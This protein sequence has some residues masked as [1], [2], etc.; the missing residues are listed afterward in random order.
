MTKSLLEQSILELEQK[1]LLQRITQEVDPYLEMADLHLESVEK[2]GPAL[3]FEKVKGS[4]FRAV[5]NLF[6]TEERAHFLLRKSFHTV[7]K[8]FQLKA[9]PAAM[10]R[11]E[12]F[13][14]LKPLWHARTMLPKKV[15][16]GEVQYQEIQISDLPQVQSWPMDGGAFL[17]L[18]QV[19]SLHPSSSSIQRSNLGMYRIQ[20]SGNCYTPDEEIGLHYQI[21]RTIGVHHTE[22]VKQGR[23]LKVSIFLGG[24]PAHTLA[25]V[26]PAPEN[27]SELTLA[28]ALAG[29]RFRYVEEDGF[30]LSADADFC[31]TGEIIPDKLLPE[32]PFGDHLGYYSLQHDFPV[33]KVHKVYARKD[34]IF[35][36]TVVGRPPQEDTLFGK[37]IHELTTPLVPKEVPGLHALH[38]VDAA[39]VHPLLLAIGSERY[40]P[41]LERRCPQELLTLSHAILGFGQCSLAKY[42]FIIAKEDAPNLDI[43]NIRA[44]FIHLLERI[45][46]TRDLHFHTKTTIDTLDYTGEGLNSG[47]KLVLAATGTVKRKLATTHLPLHLPEGFSNPHIALPGV[48]VIQSTYDGNDTLPALRKALKGLEGFPLI[49][50]ADDSSFTSKRLD[51]FLWVTFTR[52]NPSHDVHGIVE[53]VVDKHF[54]IEEAMIIDARIKPHHA[55]PLTRPSTL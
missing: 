10:F 14:L 13:R 36:F 9:D 53:R 47:S 41:Y 54:V 27:I 32:G 5:S 23:P 25:A 17:T 37:L 55:P 34:A 45:D 16:Y 39:G 19:C 33:L 48:L 18:P 31:I 38:A 4:P 52:S 2:Q 21:H 3:L 51:N 7:Q 29:Q 28:G 6:G 26:L 35:P 24:H 20:I 40:T 43:E 22:A 42:L 11:K 44:F 50:L 12:H 46:L 1:G 49:V 30:I 8:L 15:S